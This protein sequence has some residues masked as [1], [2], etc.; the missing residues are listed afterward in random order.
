MQIGIDLANG[1]EDT[2]F[3]HPGNLGHIAAGK[4][5]VT[6]EQVIIG[7]PE[8]EKRS[9]ARI[10]QSCVQAL[11]PGHVERRADALIDC[12]QALSG[13]DDEPRNSQIRELRPAIV[14]NQDVARL[15]VAVNETAM[16]KFLKPAGDVDDHLRCFSERHRAE[17][18]ELGL[19]A[20][21]LDVFHDQVIAIRLLVLPDLEATDD[22]RVLDL[23]ADLS[24]AFKAANVSVIQCEV[25][26]EYLGRKLAVLLFVVDEVD[27]RHAPGPE[28]AQHPATPDALQRR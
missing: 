10:D 1:L 19:T 17:A 2:H 16:M 3:L 24:F 4:R 5:H 25:I 20:A 22:V 18:I 21:S 7:C 23:L 8:Q 27:F 28:P 12:G 26:G 6:R 15:H 14:A 9:P 11:F 13:I